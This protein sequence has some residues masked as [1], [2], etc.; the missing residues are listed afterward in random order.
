ME[1][2]R[3]GTHALFRQISSGQ[4]EYMSRDQKPNPVSEIRIGCIPIQSAPSC[5][6]V[7]PTRA[8]PGISSYARSARVP[9]STATTYM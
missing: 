9:T 4:L 5:R 2:V 3:T 1:F 7:T 8:V 6:P